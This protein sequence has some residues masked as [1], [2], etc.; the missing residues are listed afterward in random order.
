MGVLLTGLALLGGTRADAL[1][2]PLEKQFFDY[3][4]ERCVAGLKIEA[5]KA[6]KNPDDAPIQK[7][8]GGYCACT[9]QAVVS[10]LDAEEIVIFA[11]DPSKPQVASKMQPYFQG[12][13]D[14]SRQS[15]Q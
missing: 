10:F 3:F 5:E 4:N 14:K 1:R 15:A 13:K 8:I 11:I 2:P 12:C 7:T 6:G 9:S